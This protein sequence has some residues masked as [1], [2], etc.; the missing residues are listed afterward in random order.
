MTNIDID[1]CCLTRYPDGILG[2][3]AKKIDTVDENIRQLAAKMIDIMIE[4]SGVGLAGPQVGLGLRIFVFS[5]D[6]TRESAKVYINPEIE[7]SGGLESNFEGCLSLPGI[8]GSIKRYKKC[9]ITA[10]DLDGNRFTEDAEGLAVR[11]L[12]HE[13]DH[14]EGM[15]IKDRLGYAAKLSARKKLKRLEEDS[16]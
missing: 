14:L 4:T 3:A 6:G 15:M 7:T 13:F 9:T 16:I 2:E 8:D 10:T 1:K 11:G 5:A 12:Q